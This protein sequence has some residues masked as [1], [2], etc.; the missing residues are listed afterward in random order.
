MYKIIKNCFKLPSGCV[1][2]VYRKKRTTC[3]DLSPVSKI[4]HNRYVIIPKFKTVP[5]PKPF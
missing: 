2:K 5:D 4:P 3:F 1:Q